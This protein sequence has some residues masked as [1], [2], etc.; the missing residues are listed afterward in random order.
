MASPK[1]LD[2]KVVLVFGVSTVPRGSS[3]PHQWLQA[4]ASRRF[5]N[6]S[7]PRST[8]T[9]QNSPL[10]P[11]EE[12]LLPASVR[13]AFQLLPWA[14]ARSFEV[15]VTVAEVY[16]E[17]VHDLLSGGREVAVRQHPQHGLFAEGLLRVVC[18]T[19]EE[20]LAV[21]Q[22]ALKQRCA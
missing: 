5:S 22:C 17:R 13:Q 4:T 8:T 10:H 1:S 19:A 14:A 3:N 6:D 7:P 2:S 12:G 9:Q 15:S 11:A 21:L 20:A 16:N 18:S